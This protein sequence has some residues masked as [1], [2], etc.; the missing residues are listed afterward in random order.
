[1][2]AVRLPDEIEARLAALAERTGGVRASTSERQCVST[3]TTSKTITSPSSASRS[4]C[5][6]SL[7]RRWSGGLAWRIEFEPRALKE[8]ESQDRQV[9]RRLLGF[10]RDR[11]ALLKDPRDLG[12]AL[13]GGDWAGSGSTGSAIGVWSVRF[14]T[15]V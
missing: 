14:V 3:S 11:I 1:M 13:R 5:R 2:L 12:E 6:P 4:V 7:S 8:L 10:L 9:Q 15:S